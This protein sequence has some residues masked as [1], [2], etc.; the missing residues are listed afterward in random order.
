VASSL[1][2]Q[3]ETHGIL[4]HQL[5]RKAQLYP[6]LDRQRTTFKLLDFWVLFHSK[7]LHWSLAKLLEKSKFHYKSTNCLL[8]HWHLISWWLMRMIVSMMFR[9]SLKTDVT[10]MDCIWRVA[11][12][13][14]KSSV[15]TNNSLKCSTT[16]FRRFISNLWQKNS[17]KAVNNTD[18]VVL[19]T[20]PVREE[21]HSALL[22]IPQISSYTFTW[23]CKQLIT[24][25]IGSKGELQCWLK[26]MIDIT[27]IIKSI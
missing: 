16:K 17:W 9:W 21:E 14:V 8:T 13:T 2:S 12:G 23:T 19:F 3:F 6:K 7:F 1:L 15:W 18:I 5:H 20:K 4:D 25:I 22:D 11:D 26:S 24:K 27:F 10:L